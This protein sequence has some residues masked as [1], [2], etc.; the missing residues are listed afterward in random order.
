MTP[1]D[2]Q[3]GHPTAHQCSGSRRHLW[4]SPTGEPFTPLARPAP[5][6][7][8]PYMPLAQPQHHIP[9]TPPAISPQPLPTESTNPLPAL[10]P[11]TPP[12]SNNP[13]P[14]TA[15]GRRS[16]P[17]AVTGLDDTCPLPLIQPPSMPAVSPARKPRRSWPWVVGGI[18]VLLGIIGLGI[19]G[20]GQQS[21]TSTVT[22]AEPPA[23]A[24]PPAAPAELLAAPASLVNLATAFGDG[25][26]VVGIDIVPGAYATTGPAAGGI[27]T[28]SWSRLKDT[29]GN[30]DSII[31]SD[32]QRGPTTVTIT[33]TD[34]VFNTAGCTTWQEVVSLDPQPA[35]G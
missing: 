32:V 3:P 9:R 34:G 4:P 10:G 6:S 16:Y 27:G 18:V 33:N 14:A 35:T 20:G 2:P 25:T 7:A 24:A 26:Y 11:L 15:P 19:V 21:S 1:T 31:T 30:V 17:P 28:C 12:E 5:G 8:A 23:P 22:T 29:S 13:P